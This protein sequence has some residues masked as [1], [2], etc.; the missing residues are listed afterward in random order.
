VL[1]GGLLLLA[2][3]GYVPENCPND[4]PAQSTCSAG[5]PSYQTEVKPVIEAHCLKCHAPGGQEASKDFTTYQ[6]VFTQRGPMLTQF[7][8]CRMP[9]EGEMRPVDPERAFLLKWL[10]CGAPNN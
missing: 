2:C 1:C 3:G 8:S 10:V 7:Y 9:P 4:L 6:N 5:I